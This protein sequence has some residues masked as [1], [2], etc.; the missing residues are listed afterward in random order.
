MKNDKGPESDEQITEMS[1]PINRTI[2]PVAVASSTPKTNQKKIP[3]TMNLTNSSVATGHSYEVSVENHNNSS[4]TQNGP[5]SPR[6]V[7]PTADTSAI[8]DSPSMDRSDIH[9]YNNVRTIQTT[10][11]NDKSYGQPRSNQVNAERYLKSSNIVIVHAEDDISDQSNIYPQFAQTLMNSYKGRSMED[12]PL[13]NNKPKVKLIYAKP[14]KLRRDLMGNEPRQEVVPVT[15]MNTAP[16]YQSV[17][18]DSN[19]FISKKVD[20]SD[21][22]E[23]KYTTV[24]NQFGTLNDS[25]DR[26]IL[27]LFDSAVVPGG[28]LRGVVYITTK[29]PLQLHTLAVTAEMI[30]KTVSADEKQ[31]MEK[32]IPISYT[33]LSDDKTVGRRRPLRK[34]TYQQPE[35]MQSPIK[36]ANFSDPCFSPYIGPVMLEPGDHA[37]PFAFPL[38]SDAHPSILLRGKVGMSGEA[39]IVHRY[40]IYATMRLNRANEDNPLTISSNGLNF[41]VLSCGPLDHQLPNGERVPAIMQTFTMENRQMLIQF[42][43]VI[44]QDSDDINIYIFTDDPTGLRYAEAYLLRIFHI[45]GLKVSDTKALYK[46]KKYPPN[47]FIDAHSEKVAFTERLP[48]PFSEAAEVESARLLADSQHLPS[49]YRDFRLSCES[50]NSAEQSQRTLQQST[51]KE[52]PRAARRAGCHIN[53]SIPL[54]S[55][56]QSSLE[57]LK[58]TYYVRVLI[59]GKRK[60]MAYSLP[61]SVVEQRAKDYKMRYLGDGNHLFDPEYLKLKRDSRC[62]VS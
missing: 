52:L 23:Q 40:F 44:L 14:P 15:K 10:P 49:Q 30:T 61:I 46:L 31:D 8:M 37:I 50:L 51:Y 27:R 57:A 18:K 5:Y 24:S 34:F 29:N 7:T 41:K 42:D 62:S 54:N 47:V 59:H 45:P 53:M 35:F 3:I 9:S 32:R 19:C 28:A 6:T 33:V 48:L 43:S 17:P 2:S 56:P 39:E 55:V 26:V 20:L 38:D 36:E 22:P 13:M 58:I 60:V 11:K 4:I 21:T 1:S 16:A 25:L 12:S